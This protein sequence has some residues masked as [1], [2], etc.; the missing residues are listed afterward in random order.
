MIRIGIL[1]LSALLLLSLF[2]LS[3]YSENPRTSRAAWA[4]NP[5]VKILNTPI[6]SN[7]SLGA[8]NPQ[9]TRNTS[10]NQ[11][12]ITQPIVA[13]ATVP[14]Q[15]ESIPVSGNWSL[16]IAD[17]NTSRNATLT[18]FQ[19]GDTVFGKGNVKVDNNTI[20]VA[21]C[22]NVSGNRLN[23]DLVTLEEMGLY[24]LSMALDG[25]S[26]IGNCTEFRSIGSTSTG[27][28]KGVR[29]SSSS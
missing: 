1:T 16:E 15:S 25:N 8:S 10:L 5:D 20:T 24:Q 7:N 26:A 3:A 4:A 22:G 13:N 9:Q 2:A 12:V 18:I 28:V 23:L 29:F 17:N 14:K 21:A 6:G 19:S 27:I 11:T